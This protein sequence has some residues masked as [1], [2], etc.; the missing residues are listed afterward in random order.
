MSNA[1]IEAEQQIIKCLQKE[2]EK[3]YKYISAVVNTLI[4][5]GEKKREFFKHL[6]EYIE[7]EIEL[8]KRCDN[9]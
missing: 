7:T 2:G 1:L 3:H 5:S 9:A 6:S 8:S 4:K